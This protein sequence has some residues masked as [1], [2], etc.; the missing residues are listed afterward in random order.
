MS[1]QVEFWKEEDFLMVTSGIRGKENVEVEEESNIGIYNL[2]KL[3]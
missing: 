2:S 1:L 3:F